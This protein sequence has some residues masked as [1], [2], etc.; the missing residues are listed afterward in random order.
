MIN[1]T[2]HDLP[3]IVVNQILW[4]NN[5]L[6]KEGYK[7]E[8]EVDRYKG[9]EVELIFDGHYEEQIKRMIGVYKI[10]EDKFNWE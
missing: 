9:N 1:H 5:R 3:M 2:C 8:I 7:G 10:K 4:E 6:R